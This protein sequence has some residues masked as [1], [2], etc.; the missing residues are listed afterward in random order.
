MEYRYH[1]QDQ[2]AVSVIG[3]G[4]WQLGNNNV[5]QGTSFEEG[6]KLV[7]EA[8]QN[9]VTFFDT[10]PNYAD[11]NSEK[12]LGEAIKPFREKVIINTKV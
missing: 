4:G 10:A 12:I 3:F 9:G 7:Q 8:I 5:W 2:K 6:I 1:F 11:G